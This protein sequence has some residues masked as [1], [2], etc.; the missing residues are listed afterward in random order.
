VAL[1]LPVLGEGASRLRSL[2][3]RT[4][5][6]MAPAETIVLFGLLV[7]AL[8]G[9][10][11]AA[12]VSLHVLLALAVCPLVVAV[13]WM[14]P[15]STI[16]GLAF[17]LVALGMVRRLIG[18]GNSGGLGDPFLLVGPAVLVLLLVVAC[19]QGALRKR[20][21]LANAIGLLSLLVLVEAV[22]PLQ[23]GLLV[24]VG[25]LLFILVPM[26]AFWVGR[27]LLDDVTLRRLFRLIAALSVLSATYGLVQ[28]FVGF[29]SWDER[30]IT[31]SGYN[32]L[33]VGN[34]TRAFG[35]FSSA[36]EYAVFLSVGLVVLVSSLRNVRRV[37]LPL[38]LAAIGLVGYALVL[39]SVRSS[40]VLAAAALGS[41]AAARVKLRPGIALLAGALAVVALGIGLSYVSLSA[42]TTT[43]AVPNPTGTLLQHDI[44]GITNPTGSS[45]S[46]PG[47]LS[48]TFA[49]IKSA[50]SQPIGY[51]TGS[52]TLAS[53]HLGGSTKA[54]TESDVGNAGTGL[55]LLGLSLYVVVVVQGLLCTYRLAARRRDTLAL[56]ALGLL[57]VTLFQWLNGDLYS[58]AWLVWL[59]LGW[60]DR[61]AHAQASESDLSPIRREKARRARAIA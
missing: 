29:P 20:S 2:S 23:G 49:G 8:F 47:H 41:I 24:G 50:F 5:R 51:G 19:G 48:E 7:A 54:G 37:L 10:L 45:S 59:S 16:L 60:V 15:R 52:V 61:N 14:S 40:I 4:L 6:R 13:V 55:G 12:S 33:M 57:V 11:L 30:W 58:V 28:Q 46:L 22:N 1:S 27:S 31:S 9:A 18:S 39:A 56:A 32:A 21:P 43:S 26:L 25:G 44:S 35:N 53:G 42:Q 34:T 38:P 17:W 3:P 36:Q